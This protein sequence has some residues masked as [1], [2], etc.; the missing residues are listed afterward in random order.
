MARR[1]GTRDQILD[2]ATDLFGRWGVE[3][4]SLDQIAQEVG[5]AKQTLLYWFASK[6]ELVE[7]VL[8]AT[9]EELAVVVEAAIRAAP[10]DPLDRIE[11]VVKAVFRPAVRRP[12]LLGLIREMSRLPPETSERVADH[13]RPLVERAIAWMRNEMDAGRLRRSD[14][15]IV[16]A[17]SYATVTGIA[18]EPEALRVV[19]W[20]ADT[21]G[22]RRL[23]TE[24]VAFLRSALTP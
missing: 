11:A 3:A 4:V 13:L 21:A 22:L 23:R 18:T 8:A 16:V 1:S 15:D 19:G 6:D 5:V 24:L 17:L 2:R 9:A 7:S 10:D 14:P 12:A 20:T